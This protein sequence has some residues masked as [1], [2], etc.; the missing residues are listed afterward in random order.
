MKTPEEWMSQLSGLNNPALLTVN[1]M[2]I[3][4]IQHDAQ[5]DITVALLDTKKDLEVADK[6]CVRTMA[7]YSALWHKCKKLEEQVAD[8]NDKIKLLNDL[9]NL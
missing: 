2:A 5:R 9:N 7:D 1:R 6:I 8:L 4:E 3:R